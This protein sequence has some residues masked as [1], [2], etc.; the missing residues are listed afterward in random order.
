M[1]ILNV[2]GGLEEKSHICLLNK[3]GEEHRT[4]ID[5]KKKGHNQLCNREVEVDNSEIKNMIVITYL[6]SMT[7]KSK[8]WFEDVTQA[9]SKAISQ[10]N[11]IKVKK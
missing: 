1:K 8:D 10:G 2:I 4:G 6:E 7:T 9:I 3:K 5:W 11:V